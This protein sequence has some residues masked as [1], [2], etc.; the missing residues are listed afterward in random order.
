V[1]RHEGSIEVDSQPGRTC[2]TVTLPTRQS[3]DQ[4]HGDQP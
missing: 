2:F 3:G 4:P 1:L